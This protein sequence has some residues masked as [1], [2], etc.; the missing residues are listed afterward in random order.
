VFPAGSTDITQRRLTLSTGVTLRVVEGGPADGPPVLMLPGWGGP[1][2]MYRHAF[3]ELMPKG[4]RLI[5][6]ELR[7]FGLSDKPTSR[8]QYTLERYCADLHALIPALGYERVAL[9]GQSM[10]GAIA[11]RYSLRNPAR[12]SKLVLINPAGLVPMRFLALL[13]VLPP[14]VMGLIG[15]RAV[16]RFVVELVLRVLAYGDPAKVRS[17][18]IDEYWAPTQLDGYVYAAR[19]ALSE[20]EWD[21]VSDDLA[22]SLAVPCM[23]MIGRRD[24]LIRND[25]ASAKRLAGAT[26]CWLPGGHCGH[27]EAP[28]EAYG[29]MTEFLGSTR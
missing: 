14:S 11:L 1:A 29:A 16:P 24:R 13:R 22:Q 25:E 15:R 10:G 4:Y 23:V 3:G 12:V 8:E 6:A 17:E 19:A 9:V 21:P 26:V 18:D 28:H 27:E 2:W 7:G 20:F 5:V